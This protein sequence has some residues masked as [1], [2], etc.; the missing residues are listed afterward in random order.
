MT[1]SVI[2]PQISAQPEVSDRSPSLDRRLHSVTSGEDG[3][4]DWDMIRGFGS[5]VRSG[6]STGP[7]SVAVFKSKLEVTSE[8]RGK[9]MTIWDGGCD[10]DP[11]SGEQPD[12][13]TV[14]SADM[15]SA[16]G[17]E[18]LVSKGIGEDK[19]SGT[20]EGVAVVIFP[21]SRDAVPL[22]EVEREPALVRYEMA[23]ET[24]VP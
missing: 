1:F 20:R 12:W 21:V 16:P 14:R 3:V 17:S 9:G 19:V 8:A 24:V 6:A 18:V 7:I 22:P 11:P 23:E 15:W 4:N 13:L 5:R 10:V 2:S